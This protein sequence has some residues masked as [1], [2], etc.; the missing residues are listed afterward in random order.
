LWP[1]KGNLIRKLIIRRGHIDVTLK[2]IDLV[3]DTL[4]H[5]SIDSD[6]FNLGC[7][8]EVKHVPANALQ[9][10]FWEFYRVNGYARESLEFVAVPNQNALRPIARLRK[11]R[12][13]HLLK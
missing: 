11:T 6:I 5:H 9:Q 10:N 7:H 2:E 1:S 12:V 4:P 3:I 8:V 13:A